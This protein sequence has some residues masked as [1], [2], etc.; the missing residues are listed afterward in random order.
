MPAS[1]RS[2]FPNVPGGLEQIL[3]PDKANAVYVAGLV[4]PM[5]DSDPDYPAM[6]MGNYRAG[7]RVAVV[8]AGRSRAA[9]GRALLRRRLVLSADCARSA[10][11]PDDQRHLQSQEHQEG[12][13]GHQRGA[14]RLLE[15]E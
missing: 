8:A 9:E 13:H 7:R 12:E 14:G 11:E 15:T 5:K 10:H 1:G 2:T 4:F 6:V 3:T